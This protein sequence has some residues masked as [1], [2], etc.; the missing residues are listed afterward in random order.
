MGNITASQ[1]QFL[2]VVHEVCYHLHWTSARFS[3]SAAWR[4]FV[5]KNQYLSTII[6]TQTLCN[7]VWKAV[8]R[9]QYITFSFLIYEMQLKLFVHLCNL[10]MNHTLSVRHRTYF[11]ILAFHISP[12]GSSDVTYAGMGSKPSPFQTHHGAFYRHYS[13]SNKANT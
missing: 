1:W 3:Y 5:N 11:C 7:L 10:R 9:N 4:H 12:V 6:L 2:C 13:L 8:L